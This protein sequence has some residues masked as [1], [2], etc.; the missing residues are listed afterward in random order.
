MKK[1]IATLL[2]LFTLSLQATPSTNDLPPKEKQKEQTSNELT[3][4]NNLIQVT[5]KNLEKQKSL[6]IMVQEY[7]HMQEKYL[8]SPDDNDQ[9]FRLVKAAYRL[10]ETIK[11]N[12]L[13]Q[14]FSSDFMSELN[15]FSQI[16]QKRGIPKP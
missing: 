13:S 1:V 16:A 11:E 15:L 2:L 12:N 8:K 10:S 7:Q 5:A 9:L 6:L 3:R 4:L 14:T